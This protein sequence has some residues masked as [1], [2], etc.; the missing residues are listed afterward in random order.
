MLQMAMVNKNKQKKKRCS[1]T[2]NIQCCDKYKM[3]QREL[4]QKS[5]LYVHFKRFLKTLYPSKSSTQTKTKSSIVNLIMYRYNC[6]YTQYVKIPCGQNTNK[7]TWHGPVTCHDSQMKWESMPPAARSSW[8]SMPLVRSSS[9]YVP[10][11]AQGRGGPHD[12]PHF[13][14]TVGHVT[15]TM[16]WFL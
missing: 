11:W 9:Q 4:V 10:L 13:S 16:S 3:G 15:E 14:Q 5:S 7:L 6:Y 12:N 1:Q 8:G 2:P